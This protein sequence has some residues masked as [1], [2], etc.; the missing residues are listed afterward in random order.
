MTN[1]ESSQ[2]SQWNAALYETQHSFVWHYGT[3]LIELLAPQLGER[4]L[5]LGC[6]TGQLTSQIAG[7]GAIVTGIDNSPTMIEQAIKKYPA[8]QFLVADGANFSFE[9]PFDAVFSNAALHWMKKPKP[10]IRCIWQALKSGGRFVAEFGGKGNVQQIVTAVENV[11]SEG[12]YPVK[13]DLNPWYFPS[14]GEYA[15]L[16]EQQGFYV[17]YA[18]L[19]E[20]PTQLEAGEQGIRNWLEMF[21]NSWLSIVPEK[22]RMEIVQKVETQL[23]PQLYREDAWFADYKRLRVVAFKAGH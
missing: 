22:E 4:I 3:K 12:G 23:R 13:P 10:V 20:R 9:K 11:F 1:Q 7:F 5:D 19:F 17:T 21:G 6:G 8:L 15:T 2:K 14:I 18:A 16:L